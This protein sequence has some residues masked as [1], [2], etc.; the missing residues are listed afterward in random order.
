MVETQIIEKK[1]TKQTQEK[2]K[3]VKEEQKEVHFCKDCIGYDK[4]TEREFHRKVG[5]KDE[6]GNRSEIVEVRAVCRT[7]KADSFKHLVMAN[8]SKRQCPC[9]E[10]GTYLKP[11]ETAKQPSKKTK[12]DKTKASKQ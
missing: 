11:I 8:Y 9:W 7:P 12:A 4:S 3:D 2:I 6:K 5:K 10:K 1:E